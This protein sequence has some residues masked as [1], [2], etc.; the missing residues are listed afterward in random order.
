MRGKKKK[1]PVRDG[2]P[3]K[4]GTP[5]TRPGYK[6]AAVSGTMYINSHTSF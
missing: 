6:L 2:D 4:E 1:Y 5:N 3:A